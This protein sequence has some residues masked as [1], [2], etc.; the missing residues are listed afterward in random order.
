MKASYTVEAALVCPFVCLILCAMIAVTFFLYQEVR[1]FA[2]EAV[3]EVQESCLNAQAVRL[4][5]VICK[6]E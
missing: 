1:E 6:N 5:R 3:S 4:L 2:Q